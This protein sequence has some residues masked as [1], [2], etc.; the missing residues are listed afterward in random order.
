MS[1]KA[2]FHERIPG[3]VRG[4]FYVDNQCADCD[5]CREIVPAIFG[6][7]AEHGVDYVTRQPSTTEELVECAEA[8]EGCPCSAIGD[9]GDQ[10]DW[11]EIPPHS[12]GDSS[13]SAPEP[14]QCGCRDWQ[15]HSDAP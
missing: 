14:R 1:F 12:W 4:K 15:N 2:R 13:E 7:I 5:L 11:D 10:H 9:D 8:V 6:R 3:Q